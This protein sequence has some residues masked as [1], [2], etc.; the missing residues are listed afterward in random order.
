MSAKIKLMADYGCFPIWSSDGSGYENID[1]KSLP[2]SADLQEALKKWADWYSSTLNMDNP[3]LSGFTS[4]EERVRFD[5]EGR[6]LFA[7]LRRE[8]ANIE[9]LS[10]FSVIS[11]KLE[12]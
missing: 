1:P 7:R 5:T 8:L 12:D 9:D 10:F 6:E 3:Q 11:R 4:E 2:I